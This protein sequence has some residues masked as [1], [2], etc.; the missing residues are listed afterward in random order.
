MNK[1]TTDDPWI[2]AV[3]GMLAEIKSTVK[4]RYGLTY[5]FIVLSVPD[6]EADTGH[7]YKDRFELAAEHAGL[8]LFLT[9]TLASRSALGFYGIGDCYE[10]ETDGPDSYCPPPEE[11]IDVVL[12]ISYS[13]VSLGV[14]LLARWMAGGLWGTFWPQRLSENLALGKGSPLRQQNPEKYWKDLKSVVEG[15]VKA[16]ESVDRVIFL[17]FEGGDE[18]DEL[19]RIVR[20]VVE[21]HKSDKGAPPVEGGTDTGSGESLFAVARGAAMVA[22]RGMVD[23]FDTCIMPD[24]CEKDDGEEEKEKAEKNEKGI[25]SEL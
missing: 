4:A 15:S 17:G 9:V 6:F 10:E 1:P 23:G 21:K 11:R 7:I 19:Q 3:A 12:S 20:D 24:S 25:R 14:T 8:E 22:R 18:E 16:G 13:E 2:I 5:P